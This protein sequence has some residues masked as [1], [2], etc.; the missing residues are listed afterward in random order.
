[1]KYKI[2]KTANVAN[3]GNPIN[4]A[5]LRQVR[6]LATKAASGIS[7]KPFNELNRLRGG[8]PTALGQMPG[9]VDSALKKRNR[10]INSSNP[11]VLENYTKKY[12]KIT[13]KDRSFGFIDGHRSNIDPKKLKLTRTSTVGGR[14][15]NKARV[16]RSIASLRANVRGKIY[17]KNTPELQQKY[18][19]ITNLESRL[20]TRFGPLSD[21]TN[22]VTLK[23][24]TGSKRSNTRSTSPRSN[25]AVLGGSE[26]VIRPDQLPALGGR[27]GL[28]SRMSNPNISRGRKIKIYKNYQNNSK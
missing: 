11:K 19:S 22:Y 12:G 20:K 18:R 25:D 4:K 5:K 27:A 7:L 16:K 10:V 26:R 15:L 28:D 9:F 14:E 24:K 13:K 23:S 8:K 3:F 1:M 2:V 21:S 6:H 17:D